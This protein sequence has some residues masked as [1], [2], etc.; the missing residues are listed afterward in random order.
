MTTILKIIVA[1]I[2]EG[3]VI[4]EFVNTLLNLTRTGSIETILIIAIYVIGLIGI[5]VIAIKILKNSS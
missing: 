4:T 2:I 5:P 1:S 3:L